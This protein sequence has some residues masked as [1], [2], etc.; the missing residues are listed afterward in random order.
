MSD[1]PETSVAKTR[2]KRTGELLRMDTN[3]T[4]PKAVGIIQV[5][6]TTGELTGQ[7]RKAL[8]WLLHNAFDRI[9][10]P[11]V[12]EARI[13]DLRQY[14]TNHE[15][16][17]RIKDITT[18][19][20]STILAYDYLNEDGLP[21]WGAGSLIHI[22]GS[23][24]NDKITYE[25]PHWL[26]PLLSE[27][28][29]WA[30]LSLRIMQKFSSK[31]ALTLYENL[32]ANANKANSTWDINIDDFR[33]VLGVKEGK[34]KSFNDLHRRVIEPALAEINEHADF[35]AKYVIARRD[36]RKVVRLRFE[37]IKKDSRKEDEKAAKYRAKG[38]QPARTANV[39]LRSDTFD[40]VRRAAPGA[41]VYAIERDWRDWISNKEAPKNPDGA[42]ISFAKK[43]YEKR[44]GNFLY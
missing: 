14:L 31:Y 13:S 43:W 11:V 22:S 23:S 9:S 21:E 6:E 3:P 17:D 20:G 29:K 42:F 25:F 18:R 16:N 19:L 12:H 15:S 10:E 36:G 32:E 33:A 8:N 1:N 39:P 27:P 7:D 40:K 28:A 5:K 38:P 44:Q 34:L 2:I 4:V 37:I 41:D 35:F 26:R 30:R 24:K